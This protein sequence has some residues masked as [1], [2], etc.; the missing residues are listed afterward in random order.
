MFTIAKPDAMAGRSHAVVTL[1]LHNIPDVVALGARALFEA[2]GYLRPHDYVETTDGRAHYRLADALAAHA[3]RPR[4]SEAGPHRMPS[5]GWIFTDICM[6]VPADHI[7]QDMVETGGEAFAAVLMSLAGMVETTFG[8]RA[9]L[10]QRKARVVAQASADLRDSVML[11][12]GMNVVVPQAGD[13][14]CARL[15]LGTMQAMAEPMVLVAA[16][17]ERGPTLVKMPA[18]LYAGQG[19]ITVA[20]AIGAS[21]FVAR[22]PDWPGKVVLDLERN[23]AVDAQGVPVAGQDGA[24]GR[25]WT[26]PDCDLVVEVTTLP[27]AAA[28]QVQTPAPAQPRQPG[29]GRNRP[30]G[31]WARLRR[32]QPTVAERHEPNLTP[33]P[34]ASR[35]EP[36]LTTLPPVTATPSR[37]PDDETTVVPTWRKAPVITVAASTPPRGDDDQTIVV[38]RKPPPPRPAYALELA[39]L[40]LPRV[41]LLPVQPRIPGWHLALRADGSVAGTIG[42]DDLLLGASARDGHLYQRLPG[43]AKWR[44]LPRL[45]GGRDATLAGGFHLVP[46]PDDERYHA[47]LTLP[48]PD[49]IAVADA[50]AR[51]FG[52]AGDGEEE[53]DKLSFP[54]VAPGAFDDGTGDGAPLDR[55]ISRR[56]LTAV[57]AHAQLHLTILGQ[58]PVWKLRPDFSVADRL[59][60]D[61]T[62]EL[63]MASGDLFMVGCLVVRFHG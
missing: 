57:L 15:R 32:R 45:G 61:Q 33:P 38:G 60:P 28:P 16:P 10:R 39:A 34:S 48:H 31:L 3:C 23:Q 36:A 19:R 41:D 27:T 22:I 43:A 46:S 13:M 37:S 6:V 18:G 4:L 24:T 8:Q 7:R 11:M 1:E 51:V 14:P 62:G 52:R 17:G 2:P 47:L 35:K 25:R 53:A 54:P 42:A 55:L 21:P 12:F 49:R 40:A 50:T 29:Q 59:E 44:I 63:V 58:T 20:S 26:F 5:G 56:H 30:K 9:W